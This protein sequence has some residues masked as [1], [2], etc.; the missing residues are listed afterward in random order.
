MTSP[1]PVFKTSRFLLRQFNEMDLDIVFLGLSHPDVIKYYGVRYASQEDAKKQMS[2][3]AELER[4]GTGIW[5]AVCSPDN[6][7]FYGAGGING[8]NNEHKKAEIGCW[9]LPGYWGKG[10]MKEVMPVI[11]GYGF[12]TMGLHRIE[13]L[14][15]TGN[16]NC[17]KAMA[18]MDFIHE[19]TM[20]D[21]EIK[22]GKWISLDIYAKINQSDKL[23]PGS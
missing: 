3:F 2:W 5:W 13:G 23:Q 21:C 12:N 6:S 16:A 17:K 9:I 1:F 22:D 14:V 7:I 15:E 19:G 10:I 8:L 20:I 18:K 4:N 11:T